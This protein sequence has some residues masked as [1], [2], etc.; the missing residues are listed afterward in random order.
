MHREE[1]EGR[2]RRGPSPGLAVAVSGGRG[3]CVSQQLGCSP[4]PVAWEASVSLKPFICGCGLGRAG[5]EDA[6]WPLRPTICCQKPKVPN[7]LA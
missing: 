5:G 4:V 6:K 7:Q 2:P 1:G 3:L